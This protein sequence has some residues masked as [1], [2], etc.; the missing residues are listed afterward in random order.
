MIDA[1]RD[2]SEKARNMG[3][4]VAGIS[5]GLV[6]GPIFGGLLSDRDLLGAYASLELPFYFSI[7]L[8][9]ITIL[10]VQY[11][12]HDSRP[13]SQKVPVKLSEVFTLLLRIRERPIVAR[14][15]AVYFCFM[16]ANA[17][18]YIFMTN[19]MTSRFAIGL[20][21]DSMAMMVMGIALAASSS[22]MVDPV[23]KRFG[24]KTVIASVSLLMIA[25]AVGFSLTPVVILCYVFIATFYAGFGVAYP[26]LLSIFSDSVGSDEQGWVIGV[27][28]AGF[29]LAAGITSLMGGLLMAIDIQYLRQNIVH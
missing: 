19:Y 27:T 9:V 26:A 6:A 11:Y 24:K 14:L 8:V 22:L 25:S 18:F 17:T 1:S 15:F 20:L 16:A 4:I 21:G 29:T 7:S 12:F 10:L 28:T 3:F 23:L 2:E 13:V 5:A